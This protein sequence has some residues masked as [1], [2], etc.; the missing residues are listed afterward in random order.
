MEM[1]TKYMG[2]ELKNPLVIAA[3]SLSSMIDRIELVE[4]TGAGALVIRSLF[5][6]QIQFD[7]LRFEEA[8]AVGSD[9]FPESL[10]YLPEIQHAGADEHLR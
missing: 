5:E 4:Q 7:A 3:C 1:K 2:I 10:S 6:E 8:L 9:Q